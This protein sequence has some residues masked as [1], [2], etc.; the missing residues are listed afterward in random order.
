MSS[1]MKRRPSLLRSTPP[2]PRTPSVTR[3]PRTLIG[4]TMPVGW[5]WTNS[6]SM[7]LGA[8][9]IRERVAVARVL[10]T[11]A[12]DLEGAADAAGRQHHGLRLPQDEV[13]FLAIVAERARDAA[14]IHQQREHGAF[15]VDFHAAVDAVILQRADHFEAGAVADMRQA[16]IAMPAEVALQDPAVF[17]AVEERAPRFEFAHALGRF[18]GVQLR[19]APVVQI[20]AAAHGVGEMDAP[21]V[22][23]IDIGQGRGNAAFGHHG[24]GFAQQRFA[25]HAD[26]DAR[27]PPLQSPRAVPRRPRR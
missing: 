17:R 21:V 24:V 23:V 7:Q 11:V 12:G 1:N 3:M 4:Q 26:F 20:L 2:S 14:R 13:A 27:T 15:H 19:H 6:M 18:L 25:H 16:G 5:N 8:G 22:A 10:P 9:A